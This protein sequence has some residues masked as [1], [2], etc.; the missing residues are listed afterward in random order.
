MPSRV[1]IVV[2]EWSSSWVIARFARYLVKGNRW[3][4]GRQP[5][6]RADVNLF[7]PYLE[8]RF[9]KWKRTSA[10]FFTHDELGN[11]MKRK[12]WD[13][14]SKKV[15]LR[16]TMAERY[17]RQ[18]EPRGRTLNIPPPVELDLFRSRPVKRRTP[19][20]IGVGG[21]VYKYGRKGEGLVKRLAQDRGFQLTASGVGWPC[22]TK[23]YQ[24]SDMCRFYHKL[25][26]FLC[27][28]LIEGGPITV[29]EALASGRPVVVPEGVGLIDE[30]P[31]VDGIWR[32]KAGD[33]DS[34]LAALRRALQEDTDPEELRSL[35][36]DHSVS[37]YCADWRA[38]VEMITEE[39]ADDMKI[40]PITPREAVRSPMEDGAVIPLRK[41]RARKW[42][43]KSGLYIVAYGK[44]AHDCAYHLIRTFAKR[45]PTIPVC[46]V[47]EGWSAVSKRLRHA[48]GAEVVPL[49]EI[50]KKVLRPIDIVVASA[51]SDRRARAQ[52]TAIYDLAPAEWEYVLYLDA[53]ILV[54][55][56]L[57]LFFDVLADGWEMVL[58]NSPPKGPLVSD[59]QRA[60]YK[61]ENHYT[62]G[63]LGSRDLLQ[64]AGGVWAFRR[65]EATATFMRGFH[66]EW[67]RY[68]HTDQQAM[69]RA[70]WKWPVRAWIL[71]T[72]WNT[73][74]HH[75]EAKRT[76][77]VLHF[78]TAARAWVVK[79]DGRKLWREWITKL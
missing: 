55:G 18:L 8:W 7:F 3:R 61:E 74:V 42:H 58:T 16:V 54:S 78:A 11:A 48:K 53:D 60:K 63:V 1:H 30:L 15:A 40:R 70:L 27:T 32:Y 34:M 77:G 19:P 12:H 35:V 31:Q 10:A 36:E 51:I 21:R 41:G 4:V 49:P 28:S 67:E 52:K 62:T 76:A 17:A 47:C 50:F 43:G 33:Y 71:G 59:A 2:A 39:S 38:A 23:S 65:C 45:H 13:Y 22:R 46:L 72:E 75:G 56:R 26:V 64:I 5:D 66:K 6:P 9:S 20:V 29:L 79:H 73:F 44:M 25:D 69:M 24:W 68:Q 57:E 14:I 37:R